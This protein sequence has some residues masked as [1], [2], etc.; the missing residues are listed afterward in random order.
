MK[1]EQIQELL[2][3]ISGCTFALIDTQ[4]RPSVG[5]R[6]VVTGERVILFTNQ[7]GSGYENM[8]RRRLEVFGRDPNIFVL[9]DLPWGERIP[10]SP[11]IHHNEK[12]YLQTICLSP[13]QS[14]YFIGKNTPIDGKTL[15]Y[16]RANA[17][18]QGLPPG[19]E[20]IV[21]TYALDNITRIVVMGE[22]VR[23]S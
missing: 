18:G 10:N 19:K 1:L 21:R 14:S 2:G 12:H 4:T 15:P 9:S 6:K 16:E 11:L 5:I 7:K 17:P 13:G 3:K 20:V 8:V 22:E 23:A